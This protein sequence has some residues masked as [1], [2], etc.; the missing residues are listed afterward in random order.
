MSDGL[1]GNEWCPMGNPE[2][3]GKTTRQRDKVDIES[4]LLQAKLCGLHLFF[5]RHVLTPGQKT[6]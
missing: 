3:A 5:E 1:G 4:A 6:H 2:K